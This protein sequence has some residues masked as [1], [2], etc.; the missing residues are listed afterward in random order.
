MGN[1]RPSLLE[2]PQLREL[3]ASRIPAVEAAGSCGRSWLGAVRLG[4]AE[5]HLGR[6]PVQG[7]GSGAPG[8]GGQREEPR[9]EGSASAPPSTWGPS[10]LT[11][12][13]LPSPPFASLLLPVAEC[14]LFLTPPTHS[15]TPG[16]LLP[17]LVLL[18]GSVEFGLNF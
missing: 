11:R 1:L 5:G 13:P 6:P 9:P 2:V 17:F 3:R 16:C 12:R 15:R 4:L 7:R 8:P 14:I 10:S 18:A